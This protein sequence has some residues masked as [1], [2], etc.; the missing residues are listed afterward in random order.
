MSYTLPRLVGHAKALELMMLSPKLSAE[1]AQGL[2]LVN[3]A[4]AEDA[5]EQEVSALARTLAQGPTK[6]YG[7][8]K[9]ALEKSATATLPEVLDY[10]ASLQEMAGRSR[11]HQEGVAAFLAKRPPAFRGK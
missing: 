4:V 3:R 6:A 9:R 1:E 7:L 5:F 10:E 11:D 8:M 2:G